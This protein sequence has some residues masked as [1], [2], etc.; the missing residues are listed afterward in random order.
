ML[1][2]ITVPGTANTPPKRYNNVLT[3]NTA[4]SNLL[5]FS[6]PQ[7]SAL[8]SWAAALRLASWEKS[9]LEEIY[10]AHLIR[11]TLVDGALTSFS[12]RRLLILLFIANT[13]KDAKTPLA[14][15][16]MEGW[17]RIRL[18]GQTN[19][20]KLWMVISRGSDRPSSPASHV[21]RS[22]APPKRRISNIFSRETHPLSQPVSDKPFIAFYAS[23]KPRERRKLVLS[24]SDVTQAFAVY[25]E[26][27]ELINRST[28]MK[29]E[30][31]IGEEEVAQQ[32]RGKEGWLLI[33]PE[34]EEG[35]GTAVEM[36]KWIVG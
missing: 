14:R 4:G 31:T 20:R 5:L 17:V 33:M 26:R 24:I 32:M 6:C 36:L 11:I 7:T 15:G 25:P 29:L 23:P 16:Q 22:A 13:G 8:M 27:P 35:M 28:L 2:S 10:T 18:A 1:G 12:G 21:N 34:L 19:W 3:L 30:G 9:R